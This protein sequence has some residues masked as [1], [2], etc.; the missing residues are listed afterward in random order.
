MWWGIF[1]RYA[2]CTAVRQPV[3]VV[4]VTVLQATV[5]PVTVLQVT[6][7]PVMVVPVTYRGTSN[8]P[9][10]DSPTTPSPLPHHST[11]NTRLLL[12]WPGIGGVEGWLGN[13]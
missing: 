3:M 8:T 10:K 6:V 11:S 1:K 7:V 9:L 12:E 5:V 13:L 2:N 4:P